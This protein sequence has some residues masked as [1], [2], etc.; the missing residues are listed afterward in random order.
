MRAL[1]TGGAGFIGSNL[2]DALLDSGHEV[3]VL[4]DLS[5]GREA[6]LADATR[7]GAVLKIVD[8]T[9][10]PAVAAA[11]AATSPDVV[12]HLAAQIDVR[13]SVLDP[14]G[15]ARVNVAGT[16]VLL[17]EARRSGAK[18]FVFSSTGGAIYGEA[19]HLPTTESEPPRALSPYG[20]AKLAAEGYVGLY[21]RLHDLST[22]SLRYANVYG[23]RQDPL[24]EGGVVAIF[25]GKASRREPGTVYGDGLQTRDFV[26]VGD[27]VAANLAAAGATVTGAFNIGTSIETSVLE[28]ADA[29]RLP[30]PEFAPERL[31]EVRRSCLDN[32][33]AAAALDWRP[34][35][36]LREGLAA[37]ADAI[38]RVRS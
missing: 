18:R 2:V 9:D 16:A 36:P 22:V 23:A 27:V 19:S 12:F 33:R 29:L 8:I 26:Y 14:A 30:G 37:T 3:V 1:V 34:A 7:R 24:G 35:T 32:A 38:E 17:E 10:S 4:D 20:Q 21:E 5:T 11:F 13:R 15:D 25:C 6:N 31:G 28:L